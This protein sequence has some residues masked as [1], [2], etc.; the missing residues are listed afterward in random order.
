MNTGALVCGLIFMVGLIIFLALKLI[1][2]ATMMIIA[3]RTI[4]DLEGTSY[5]LVQ[6]DDTIL[7]HILPYGFAVSMSASVAL[8]FVWGNRNR[9]IYFFCMQKIVECKYSR[10]CNDDR[11]K[12]FLLL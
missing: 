1:Q 7:R 11:E 5:Q 6:T 2:P 9:E 4:Y 10:Q 8:A 12:C 3:R